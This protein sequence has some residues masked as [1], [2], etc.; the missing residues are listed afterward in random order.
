MKRKLT[1]TVDEELIPQAKRQ[2]RARGISL[3]ELIERRLREVCDE[4][5]SSFSSRWRGRMTLKPRAQQDERYRRL[6]KKHQ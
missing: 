6:A 2:A 4:D 1:I 5:G 3:S